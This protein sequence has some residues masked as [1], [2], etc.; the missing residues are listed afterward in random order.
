MSGSGGNTN[1]LDASVMFQSPVGAVTLH[2]RGT[3]LERSEMDL[4][5]LFQ[6]GRGLR[7][8]RVLFVDY[9]MCSSSVLSDDR[10]TRQYSNAWQFFLD[11]LCQDSSVVCNVLTWQKGFQSSRGQRSPTILDTFLDQGS[12]FHIAI[13]HNMLSNT[14]PKI[15]QWLLL[16]TALVDLG[17]DLC[18]WDG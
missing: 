1:G 11:L 16:P 18:G 13:L 15:V 2:V 12:P 10:S 3:V 4:G 6:E 17:L 8:C 5:I 9:P 14:I 7:V